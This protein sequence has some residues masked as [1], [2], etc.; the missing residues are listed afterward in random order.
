MFTLINGQ[1]P[2]LNNPHGMFKNSFLDLSLNTHGISKDKCMAP[3]LKK[4][5]CGIVK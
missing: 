1:L 4:R 5:P 2:Y 3:L